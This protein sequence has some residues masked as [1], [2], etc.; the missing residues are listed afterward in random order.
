MQSTSSSAPLSRQAAHSGAAAM[1][2][3]AAPVKAGSSAGSTG[4]AGR[5]HLPDIVVRTAAKQN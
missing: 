4:H 2:P 5:V 1:L 3:A